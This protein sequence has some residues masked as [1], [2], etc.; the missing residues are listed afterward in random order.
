MNRMRCEYI[1]LG[2][3]TD[4]L[5]ENFAKKLLKTGRITPEMREF[6]IDIMC[7]DRVLYLDYKGSTAVLVA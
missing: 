4:E 6:V 3:A 1:R 7:G 5:V 2:F